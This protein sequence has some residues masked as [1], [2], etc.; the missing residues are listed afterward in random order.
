MSKEILVY[1]DWQPNSKPELI[2]I[3]NSDLLKG[4]E[5]FSF[6]YDSEWL[7]KNQ[8]SF[9]DPDLQL[10]KGRQYVPSDKKLFGI[11]TDSCPDRWGRLLMKRRE[12]LEAKEQ[13]RSEKKLTE[14][15][16]LLGIQD[17]ARMGALRFKTETEGAFLADSEKYKV[18]VWTSIREL[19]D[20]AYH[21]D[22]GEGTDKEI[23]QWLKIILSPGSS[24]GGARPKAT[25]K[26]TDGNLWI[27]KF[28][29]KYDD[30]DTGAWEMTVHELA[31]NCGLNVPT[32]KCEVYSKKG[33]TFL[34]KRFD[35]A[36][37]GARVHFVSAMTVL[38]KTDGES[39]VS[40]AS[41][42]DI[43]QAIRQYGSNPKEDL[44]ELWKRIAFS[45]AV[46]N[47]DDHLRNHG[48]IADAKGLR[49][50]PMYD[51]NPNPDGRALSLNIDENDNS[52]DFN[53]VLSVAPYFDLP[54][55]DAATE[56][57]K[58]KDAVKNWKLVAAK[59][60]VSRQQISL[61]GSCFL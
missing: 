56:I 24:L 42:L 22:A 21:F 9:F 31:I 46:T 23:K 50:S 60:G 51:V 43:A 41:Y 2:G 48:F 11:F 29:S 10:F 34:T 28:P 61:M 59:Y 26:D 36:D 32:A 20:A 6:E 1:S 37:N 47:T 33:S 40:G 5:I 52:L 49:L 19:E 27:A 39:A 38:G 53:L 18:P 4:K 57:C 7:A 17:E 12:A 14:S 3:L 16:Y 15:D 54:Q 30:I 44:R 58:I 8:F 45:I 55:D 25:V 13:N 35:R